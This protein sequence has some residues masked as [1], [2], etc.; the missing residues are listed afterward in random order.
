MICLCMRRTPNPATHPN[1]R[2]TNH[3][4][5]KRKNNNLNRVGDLLEAAGRPRDAIPLEEVEALVK[6][7]YA[8]QVGEG[9]GWCDEGLF[10][11][12]WGGGW[13]GG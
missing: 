5:N 9:A 8:L 12:V 6:N 7:A 10:L 1:T 11:C 4:K 3:H 13:R 2:R